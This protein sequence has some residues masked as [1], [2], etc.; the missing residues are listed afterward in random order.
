[1]KQK[2]FDDMFNPVKVKWNVEYIRELRCKELREKHDTLLHSIHAKMM[3]TFSREFHT[4]SHIY[5]NCAG[6]K[7]E[8]EEIEEDLKFIFKDWYEVSMI[9]NIMGH[10]INKFQVVITQIN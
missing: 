3:E 5:V 10:S 9:Y 8:A 2:D 1:M 4:N 6:T 7:A